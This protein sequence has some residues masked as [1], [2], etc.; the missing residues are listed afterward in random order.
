MLVRKK[1]EMDQ[2]S[3]INCVESGSGAY[4]KIYIG[5]NNDIKYAVKRR[6]ISQRED[7]PPGC[8]HLNEIDVMC[9]MKHPHILHAIYM[10]RTNPISDNFRSDNVD[11]TGRYINGVT[12]RAD[13]MYILT[14]AALGDLSAISISNNGSMVVN[15]DNDGIKVKDLLRKYMWQLLTALAYLHEHG[16]IHRDIKPANILYFNEIEPHIKICDFDMCLPMIDSLETCKAMT[17]QYTPPEILTQGGNV[18]YTPKV[19]IWG[20][21][22]VLYHLIAGTPLISSCGRTGNDLDEYILALEKR[23][24]PNGSQ[25]DLSSDQVDTIQNIIDTDLIDINLSINLGD[26]QVNDLLTHMLDCNPD[27]RWDAIQCLKHPFFNDMEIPTDI[28]YTDDFILEK[29]MI[30]EEMAKVFDSMIDKLDYSSRYGFF[31]GLD[32]LMRVCTKKYRGSGTNLAIC[33]FNLGMKFFEKESAIFIKIKDVETVKRIEASII[34]SHLFGKIYRDNVYNH[35]QDE[36]HIKRIYR[37]LMSNEILGRPFSQILK[38][39]TTA[40]ND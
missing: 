31:L 21:G 12:Y 40:L 14:E 7:V 11:T 26:D 17:P 18:I 36:K 1:I 2:I 16:Y 39:I 4:G 28:E 19:D 13:L 25:I 15:T 29:H 20:A 23:F 30:T 34:Q 38:G 6:Y 3:L 27:T 9:R 32:I 22:H 5:T 8:I 37:Y 35:I 24:L 10:Q 33:C